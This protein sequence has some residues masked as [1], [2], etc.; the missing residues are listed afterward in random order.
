VWVVV[1]AGW[2]V[3]DSVTV[4][5]GG[6]AGAQA[7]TKPTITATVAAKTRFFIIPIVAF[8]IL[9]LARR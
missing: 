8:S 3:E 4:V 7:P 9:D 1:T 5:V 6:T 2:V